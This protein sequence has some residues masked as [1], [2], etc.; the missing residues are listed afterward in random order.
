[1]SV[2]S[3]APKLAAFVRRDFR[4]AMSY[5][6]GALGGL[7]GIVTQVAAFALMG[8]L[9]DPARMPLFEGTR[10]TYIEFVVIGICLNMTLLLTLHE[11]A[12]AIRVEQL[13]GTLESLLITPTRIGTVQVGSTLFNL[14]YVPIRLFLFLAVIAVV[15]GLDLHAAGILPAIVLMVEFLAFVWGLGLIAAGAVLTFRR[16]TG[17][18][19]AGV[20][21]ISLGSGA[22][23]P[24]SVLPGWLAH[25]AAYNPLAVV[26]SALRDALIGGAGWQTLATPMLELLPLAIASVAAGIFLFRCFLRRERRLGTLGLY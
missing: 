20:A 22:F 16:G 25:I 24:L 13:T 23:F 1:V 7:L 11:L 12:R 2:I 8:K 6:M 19:G 5:R 14:L 18:I 26:L 4:V 15:F 3:E 9:V 21:V 17:T 10:A